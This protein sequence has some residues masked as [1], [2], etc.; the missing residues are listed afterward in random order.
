MSVWVVPGRQGRGRCAVAA[1]TLTPFHSNT[2][3]FRK[4]RLNRLIRVGDHCCQGCKHT[5]KNASSTKENGKSPR[6]ANSPGQEKCAGKGF[7]HI[8]RDNQIGI[9]PT[10]EIDHATNHKSSEMVG[11]AIAGCC[12]ARRIPGIYGLREG[13]MGSLNGMGV[14]ARAATA[15]R[16]GLDAHGMTQASVSGGRGCSSPCPPSP[17][18]QEWGVQRGKAPLSKGRRPAA[19]KKDLPSG[20]AFS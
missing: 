12:F 16:L 4:P 2:C 3:C 17:R 10:Q 13:R 9:D 6:G 5:P 20:Q 1:R 11:A 19:S 18:R 7:C 14:K 15:K 8:G